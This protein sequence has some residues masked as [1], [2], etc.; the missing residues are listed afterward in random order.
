MQA[1]CGGQAAQ[2]MCQIRDRDAKGM[3]EVTAGAGDGRLGRWGVARGDSWL[4]IDKGVHSLHC[5][6]EHS[7]VV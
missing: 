1:S 4:D 2:S 6:I 5:G 7:T 3:K